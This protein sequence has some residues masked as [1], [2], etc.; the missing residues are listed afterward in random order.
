MPDNKNEKSDLEKAAYYGAHGTPELK[1]DEKNRYLNEFRERIICYLNYDQVIEEAVY[2]EVI[3]AIKSQEAKKLVVSRDVELN[4]SQ[5]YINAAKNEGLSFKRVDSPEHKGEISLLV[6]SD[7]AVNV[8][9][10]EIPDR[11]EKLKKKGIP[12]NII[13]GV[14][15]KLC[16]KCWEL[17]QDK[18]EEETINYKKISWLERLTGEDCINCN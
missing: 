1:K 10:K 7:K 8:D 12:D 3:K 5:E 2:P 13:G 4:Q 14:G 17:L 6:A 9:K 18:A 11:R 15:Q 16:P